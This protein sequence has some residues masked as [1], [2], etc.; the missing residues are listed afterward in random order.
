MKSALLLCALLLQQPPPQVSR[1]RF[2]GTLAQGLKR[3]EEDRK[4]VV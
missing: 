2:E 3:I 4:S 1:P